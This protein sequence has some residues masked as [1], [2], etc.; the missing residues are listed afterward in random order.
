MLHKSTDE[1]LCF[2]RTFI[3]AA[4]L[5]SSHFVLATM[6]LLFVGIIKG[7]YLAFL[8]WLMVSIVIVIVLVFLVLAEVVI[9]QDGSFFV[10]SAAWPIIAI[11]GFL[12]L[13]WLAAMVTCLQIKKNNEIQEMTNNFDYFKF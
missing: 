11:L 8:P 3:V 5:L 12:D 6:I 9:K 1:A 10:T 4:I 13:T 2:I 7:K